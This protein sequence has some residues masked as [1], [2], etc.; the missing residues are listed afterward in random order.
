MYKPKNYYTIFRKDGIWCYACYDENNRRLQRSTGR[1]KKGEAL[2][3][4]NERIEQGRLHYP[5]GMKNPQPRNLHPSTMPTLAE[6]SEP[7]FDYDRCPLI[8]D[9]IARG[10]APSRSFARNNRAVFLKHIVPTFG[11]TLLSSLDRATIDSWLISLPSSAGISPS[12]ANKVFT[13]LNRVLERAAFEEL[14]P[15][16]PCKGIKPLHRQESDRDAF[17]VEETRKILNSRHFIY[18]SVRLACYIAASTGMRNSEIRALKEKQIFPTHI[19]VDA[20]ESDFDGRKKP[21]NGKA[22][23]VPITPSLY[24]A[25]EPFLTGDS[26]QYIFTNDGI[27]PVGRSFFNY[28]LKE[29]MKA[30]GITRPGLVFHSFRCYLD[31]QLISEGVAP[32]TVRLVL[33]HSSEEMTKKYLHQ[34]AEDKRRLVGKIAETVDSFISD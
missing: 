10:S 26:E 18:P 14:I 31:T 29:V 9:A 25:I 5:L 30:E 15:S 8:Q 4:I 12:H 33:G 7:F 17:T 28:H 32:E 6:Y 23:E 21:K 34:K 1:R 2:D 13:L 22:R 24:S 16:N 19:L 11:S 27:N 20:S 3:V